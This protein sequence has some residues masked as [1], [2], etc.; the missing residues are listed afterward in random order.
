MA[1]RHLHTI[2]EATIHP[3]PKITSLDTA[4][5]TSINNTKKLNKI[6]PENE[7]RDPPSRLQSKGSH[8]IPATDNARTITKGKLSTMNN[9]LLQIQ[10]QL[11]HQGILM[12]VSGGFLLCSVADFM[13]LAMNLQ[14]QGP[15]HYAVMYLTPAICVQISSLMEVQCVK[16]GLRRIELS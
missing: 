9:V 15:I 3:V 11:K 4:E 10:E 14:F 6:K 2:V 1:F 7:P 12:T 13:L 8:I 16:T 5:N